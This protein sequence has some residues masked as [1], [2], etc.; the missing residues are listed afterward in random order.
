M[1]ADL[2]PPMS[3][4]EMRARRTKLIK[5]TDD[6]LRDACE[7]DRAQ[8]PTAAEY[9]RWRANKCAARA[10]DLARRLEQGE[11]K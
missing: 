6:Y 9:V 7:Y 10:S 11:T 3:A 2:A 1:T 5:W 8:M 4:E